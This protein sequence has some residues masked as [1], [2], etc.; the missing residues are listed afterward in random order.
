[1]KI[2]RELFGTGV[3]RN[4]LVYLGY[5]EQ[6][7]LPNLLINIDIEGM[8]LGYHRCMMVVMVL[9]LQQQIKTAMFRLVKV[10][11]AKNIGFFSNF[12]PHQIP[13]MIFTYHIDIQTLESTMFL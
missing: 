3:I 11:N 1:M 10:T 8:I 9:L 5:F 4:T 13:R 7:N 2:G 12:F 6:L